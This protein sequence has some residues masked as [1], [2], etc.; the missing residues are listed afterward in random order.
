MASMPDLENDAFFNTNEENDAS[1]NA[2]IQITTATGSGELGTADPETAATAG[3]DEKP[4]IKA[5]PPSNTHVMGLEKDSE[6]GEF[7]K[8]HDSDQ[9]VSD[10]E[11]ENQSKENSLPKR[12]SLVQDAGAPQAKKTK[13]MDKKHKDPNEEVSAVRSQ[14]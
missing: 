10:E 6:D 9:Q 11:K 4:E 3:K 12:H 8:K 14:T 1:M 5:E 13:L 7:P 2:V